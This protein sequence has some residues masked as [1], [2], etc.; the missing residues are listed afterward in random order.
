MLRNNL[1]ASL[2]AVSGVFHPAREPLWALAP[3]TWHKTQL[4]LPNPRGGLGEPLSSVLAQG[5]AHGAGKVSSTSEA[6]P[7]QRCA[8]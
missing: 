2:R 7:V 3:I 8:A 5:F 1:W 4:S 6:H